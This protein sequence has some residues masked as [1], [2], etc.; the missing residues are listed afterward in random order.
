MS[1]QKKNLLQHAYWQLTY[2]NRQKRNKDSITSYSYQS[3]SFRIIFSEELVTP[4]KIKRH[5]T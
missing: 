3:V 2:I 4:L 1:Y 5:T